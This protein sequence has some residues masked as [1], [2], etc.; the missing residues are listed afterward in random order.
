MLTMLLSMLQRMSWMSWMSWMSCHVLSFAIL[1]TFVTFVSPQESTSEDTSQE[2]CVVSRRLPSFALGVHHSLER[3]VLERER[4]PFPVSR[5]ADG[6][7][8]MSRLL[9][10][11]NTMTSDPMPGTVYST[12]MCSHDDKKLT[13]SMLAQ[14]MSS[15]AD[16]RTHLHEFTVQQPSQGTLSISQAHPHKT[17]CASCH[18]ANLTHVLTRLMQK[19]SI[20]ANARTQLSFGE[21]HRISTERLVAARANN[22]CQ[23]L[24]AA[25]C[26][27][28]NILGTDCMHCGIFLPSLLEKLSVPAVFFRRSLEQELGVLPTL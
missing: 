13:C 20:R 26:T 16:S 6:V 4:K 18:K 3:D 8:H 28:D 21:P 23:S 12:Q 9:L 19:V 10:V 15:P 1:V 11:D 14:N 2:R 27:G 5:E 24:K 25:V 22:T 17:R 7:C